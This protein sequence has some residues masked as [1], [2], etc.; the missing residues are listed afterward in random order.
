MPDSQADGH[1]MCDPEC[2]VVMYHYVRPPAAPGESALVAMDPDAFDRQLER[3]AASREI[4]SPDRYLD[5]LAGCGGLPERCALLT[6]DDGVIDHYRHVF[7]MLQR[8]G[9]SGA[10]FVQ[11]D[12]VENQRMEATH[13]NHMLLG[14]LEID[15]L[16]AEFDAALARRAPGR[17][18]SDFVLRDKAMSLYHYESENRALYKYAV[19]FGLPFNLRDEILTEMFRRHWGDPG[20]WVRRFYLSW[21]QLAEMQAA[22]MHVGGHSHGHDV[23]PRLPRDRLAQDTRRCWDILTA[24]LGRRRRA[25]AYPFGRYNL[26]SIEAVRVAGFAAAFTT[27]DGLNAGRV[28]RFEIARTDCVAL[29]A[30]LAGTVNGRSHAHA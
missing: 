7:P 18:L 9:L 17:T 10:F 8:R 3:L 6:F 4:I 20:D 2:L 21:D 25:F 13:M 28:P 12:P 14:G 16:M 22:G 5:F 15:E 27:H 1:S 19:A 11:T 26:E 24:R 30:A 23:Y 29:D